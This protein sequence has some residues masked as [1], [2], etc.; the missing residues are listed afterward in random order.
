MS[1]DLLF[2]VIFDNLKH[3]S[4]CLSC[5]LHEW[6]YLFFSVTTL[7]NF[8]CDRKDHINLETFSDVYR[9]PFLFIPVCGLFKNCVAF[10]VFTYQ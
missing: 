6:L 3:A 8:K 1:A 9:W 7:L 10:N 2:S 5:T 4:V